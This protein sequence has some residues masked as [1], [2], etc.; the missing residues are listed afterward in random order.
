M[1]VLLTFRLWNLTSVK[2][3][4]QFNYRTH[5]GGH[6]TNHGLDW[7]VGLDWT[8]L[9]WTGLDWTGLDWTGW[10]NWT[11]LDSWTGLDW[12]D[13]SLGFCRGWRV[14]CRGSQIFFLGFVP[15]FFIIGN[16]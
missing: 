3:I 16:G 11:R 13:L 14:K 2:L 12:T 8:G 4:S 5:R 15:I 9:D 10:L 1:Q 7:T 6:G